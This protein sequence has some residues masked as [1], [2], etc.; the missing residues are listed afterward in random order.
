MHAHKIVGN[1]I[2]AA[3]EQSAEHG[4]SEQET[5]RAMVVSA[6]AR[7]EKAAGAE[8]T[9]PILEFELSNLSGTVDFVRPR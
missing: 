8:N 9:R 7:H 3:V 1:A 4:W 2:D 5:L 6:V